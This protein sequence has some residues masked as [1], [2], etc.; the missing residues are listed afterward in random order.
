MQNTTG[1]RGVWG[2]C[3]CG[4]RCALHCALQLC[5]FAAAMRIEE[6][7]TRSAAATARFTLLHI[8]Y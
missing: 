3:G 8:T 4:M 5:R 1:G 2:G 6:A 7:P